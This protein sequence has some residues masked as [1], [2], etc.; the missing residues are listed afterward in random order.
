MKRFFRR[1][2]FWDSSAKGILFALTFL[3]VGSS[4]WFTLFQMLWTCGSSQVQLNFMSDRCVHEIWT[5]AA[6]E[7][8]IILYSAAVFLRATWLL[9]V[10]C[11]RNRR[12]LPL[13]G[14][15][16]AAALG[17]CGTLFCLSPLPP[18]VQAIAEFRAPLMTWRP[19]VP[20]RLFGIVYLAAVLC[21]TAGG[22]LMVK[23]FARA[24]GR[25]LREAVSRRAAVLW[26]VFWTAYVL[27]LALALLQSGAVSVMRT[28]VM[29]NFELRPLTA[30][31]LKKYYA[32]QGPAD[33]SFW[34]RVE[35]IQARL[36]SA[37][38]IGGR[39]WE[40][41]RGELPDRWTPDVQ[42]AFEAYCR[43]NEAALLEMEACFDDVPP[44]VP[45]DFVP[46]DV[47]DSVKM[48][49]PL[50]RRF[51]RLESGRMRMFLDR[52]DKDAALR[53]YRRIVNCTEALRPCPFLIGALVWMSVEQMRLDAM[54][55][56]LESRLLT[57]DDLRLL[58][59]DVAALEERI[60]AVDWQAMYTEVA[61]MEDTWWGMETGRSRNAAIPY[62][63]L[64]FFYPQ[65]W[66]QAALDRMYMLSQFAGQGGFADMKMPVGTARMFSA[67][68][69]PALQVS[70]R[71]FTLLTAR[72][73]AMQALL[74]AEAHRREHG[75]FPEMLSDLPIDP[76][77]EK[78][79][80]YRYGDVK[81]CE[82][83]LHAAPEEEAVWLDKEFRQMK[84]V[85]VWSV[86]MNGED[87]GGVNDRHGVC[88]DIC[89][90]I[91]LE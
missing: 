24:E 27:I 91:R 64:R 70:G 85:Q 5:W 88:D 82:R 35:E 44:L 32:A 51:V 62:G 61:L 57:E 60:R 17:A 22:F 33:A 16:A 10:N 29:K 1:L 67:M 6:G 21:M 25:R 52:K 69:I 43:D 54:E 37:L 14:A 23:A 34:A 72:G 78:P 56:L 12:W 76:F 46:G 89:A 31:G 41:W 39:R 84:A 4:L 80:L 63:Q 3:F 7:L 68:I 81:V 20:P 53:A 87:D 19:I 15:L 36:P 2:F 59:E 48:P 40:N 28:M 79:M 74:R 30:D 26:G 73:R 9:V 18:L 65:L 58:E 55:K 11:R 71:K 50:F 90:R 75:D 86:G 83:V 42:T 8:L 77:T 45:L 38:V 13:W 49:F 47:A 66:F